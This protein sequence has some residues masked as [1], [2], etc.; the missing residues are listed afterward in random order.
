MIVD[1]LVDIK[2]LFPRIVCFAHEVFHEKL[3]VERRSDLGNENGIIRVLVRLR[4]FAKEAVHAMAAFMGEGLHIVELS[5]EI[6]EDVGH[7]VVASARVG[8]ASFSSFSY[9]STQR[10]KVRP[11]LKMSDIPCQGGLQRRNIIG[12]R[13][14]ISHY[15]HA[16]HHGT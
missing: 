8:A 5:L 13:V 4:L 14:E 11:F 1:S 3:F 15:F 2:R 7:A 16:A 6:H 10:S 9:R 12:R